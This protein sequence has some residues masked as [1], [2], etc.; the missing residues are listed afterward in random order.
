MDVMKWA[1]HSPD[2]LM[3]CDHGF[4]DNRYGYDLTFI[5]ILSSGNTGTE[6]HRG[7]LLYIDMPGVV[8]GTM[9]FRHRCFSMM[10]VNTYYGLHIAGMQK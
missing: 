5:N 8:Y 3:F 1:V 10:I 2:K 7:R 4:T 6:M 9:V